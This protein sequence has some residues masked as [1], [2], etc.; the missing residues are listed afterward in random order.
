VFTFI[1]A[2][3]ISWGNEQK[4]SSGTAIG[5]KGFFRLQQEKGVWW[6]LSPEGNKFVSL[7]INHIEPVLLCS[8]TNK[9]FFMEKYG[10]DL[11][12][13]GG[14]PNNSG[15][16][17]QRWLEDSMNLVQ[18][19]GF[20]SLG[21]HNPIPQSRMPYVA[22]FRPARID[23]WAGLNRQY[24]DPFDAKTEE[25]IEQKA[26]QWCARHKD[27]KM[28]LGISL[29]DMPEWSASPKEIHA[30]VKFCMEL[31]ETSPGKKKWVEVLQGNY[32][33]ASVAAA[34]Y[35]IE[36]DSWN[37]F[38]LRTSWPEPAQPGKVF[39]DVQG[40]LPRIAD[41]WF[42]IMVTAL[43]KYDHN[44]L[45]FGDK[46]EGK[47][48]LPL[49]LDII[50]KKYFDLAYIQWYDYAHRQIP[51]LKTLYQITGKPVLMGDSSFSCPTSNNPRPKGVHVSSQK[52]VGDA[53]HTYLHSVMEEPYVVGWHFCG[54]IEGS[55]DLK[56]HHYYF[57]IQ[58]GLLKPDGTPYQEAIDR[59]AAANVNASSWHENAATVSS[60]A[61]TEKERKFRLLQ[62]TLVSNN[63]P[64]ETDDGRERCRTIRLENCIFTRIDDNV[65]N[66]GGFAGKNAVPKKN[67]SWVVTDEGVVVIDTGSNYSARMAMQKIREITDKPVRYIIYTHH[68]G[69]QV[70]GT[71]MLMNPETEVIAHE[72]LVLEFDLQ[73]TFYNY[74]ARLNSIQF[75]LPYSPEKANPLKRVYPDITYTS[76]YSFSLGGKKFELYHAVGESQDY[77]IVFLPDQKI[78]WIGDMLGGG[79]PMVASPM[80][81]VRDEVK[82]K[83]GLA[84]IKGLKPEVL[85]QSVQ[86]P[87]CDQPT[88]TRKLDV[89]IE[90]L[91]FLYE[92]IAREMNAGSS[93]EETLINI[94]LP[95]HM[96]VNPLLRENYGSLQFNIR[97]LYHR[98]SGW[99]DQNG[100]HLNPA[101]AK[102]RAEH[103]IKD[104]GGEDTV[105]QRVQE[106]EQQSNYKLAL[107][108][109]DL[110]IAAGS[111]LKNAYE[112]KG[113]I[114]RKMSIDSPHKMTANMYRRL[115]TM[116]LEKARQL[117]E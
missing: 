23:G 112:A 49:W 42:R 84:L 37:S 72:D 96:R 106:L 80:K 78:I 3:F 102:E 43:R 100:T 90:Y 75:D 24:M 94:Q 113:S 41:N 44:H 21:V 5:T 51:R 11:I 26:E 86:Q 59:V 103:F 101:P 2:V 77:T 105:L 88:I 115:S 93:L 79:M 64:G 16:A 110:L 53:Y 116:E 6:F 36:A 25:F 15:K 40:F 31:D 18:Q 109:L 20:N 104:M 61:D 95:E 14:R 89:V 56:K 91:D 13:P 67:I 85:I 27:D 73:K 57:S 83:K 69:T 4:E 114:L 107:E 47:R 34:A 111:H 46:F 22:K 52:E 99:F 68:H 38:L 48:N 62:E 87:F 50:I 1:F 7:G 8:D 108:Y 81:R 28:I 29:N 35:G 117:S 65:Y 19:W 12:G 98:Y 74:Y 82:W 9:A 66:L 58:N 10:D 60:A 70:S 55:P 71:T 30:W 76:E 32:P 97:G 39:Q 54:F 45:I 33:D 63:S 92:S 17:A